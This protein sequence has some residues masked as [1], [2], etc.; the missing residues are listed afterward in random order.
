M[1]FIILCFKSRSIGGWL[2]LDSPWP[3]DSERL[4]SDLFPLLSLKT[5]LRDPDHVPWWSNGFIFPRDGH[6]T[7]IPRGKNN[8]TPFLRNRGG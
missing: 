4:E 2:R 5:F 1:S 3:R 7:Y 6:W 8:N